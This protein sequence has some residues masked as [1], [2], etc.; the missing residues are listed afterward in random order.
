MQ[1]AVDSRNGV[2]TMMQCMTVVTFIVTSNDVTVVSFSNVTAVIY[3]AH[4]Q[5]KP[6]YVYHTYSY[7]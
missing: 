1:V 2:I 3:A 7:I 4:N 6:N 5:H